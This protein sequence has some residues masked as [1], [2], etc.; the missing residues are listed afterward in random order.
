[1]SSRG[2]RATLQEMEQSLTEPLQHRN[3]E[4][5]EERMA[6]HEGRRPVLEHLEPLDLERKEFPVT[7]SAAAKLAFLLRY[8]VLA[9]S[10]HNSQ[11]WLYRLEDD[12]LL[13]LADRSR[14]L[15][16]AD[17]DDRELE[18]SCGAALFHL[19]LA[20]RHNGFKPEVELV[21]DPADRDLLARVTLGAEQ[22]PGYEDQLLFWAIA[23]RHTNRYSF[24]DKAVP[25]EL[26]HELVEAAAQEGAWL[27]LLVRDVERETL[28]ELIRDADLRQ[29]ADEAFRRELVGVDPQRPGGGGRD[30][31]NG[32]RHPALARTGGRPGDPKP[33]H[34]EERG[35]TR[36]PEA[37]GRVAGAGRPRDG[38]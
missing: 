6:Q 7:G 9:P 27:S 31:R 21:P 26:L 32:A 38:R 13:L 5:R 30:A 10:S 35:G 34:G 24:A 29:L 28:A 19:Q 37:P 22:Q 11:P 2:S 36:P 33:W 8:A 18:I 20:I 3:D 4:L 17:V 25:Q 1:M 12:S 23:K 15:P 14:A 16:V